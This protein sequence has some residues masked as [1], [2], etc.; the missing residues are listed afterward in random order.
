MASYSRSFI[1]IQIAVEIGTMLYYIPSSYSELFDKTDSTIYYTR[2][3][4]IIIVF[5]SVAYPRSSEIIA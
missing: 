4:N 2:E 5:N 1:S 3:I